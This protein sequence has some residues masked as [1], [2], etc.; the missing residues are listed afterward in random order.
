MIRRARFLAMSA[1]LLAAA[2]PA[3]RQL[4]AT[5][6]AAH[7]EVLAQGSGPVIVI[8]P[9]LGRGATDYDQLAEL[10]AEKGFRVLRPQP[11]GIGGST[12]PMTSLTLHDYA[13]DVAAVID[14]DA[15]GPVVVVGHAFGNYVARMLATD[16]P[17]LVSKLVLAAASP[18]KLPP[19][20]EG[21]V[22]APDIRKAIDA[23]KDLA[24]PDA[25]RLKALRTAFFAPGNDPHVW[26]DGWHPDVAAAEGAAEQATNRDEW[27]AG[28]HAPILVLQAAND[29]VA[30]IGQSSVLKD[31]LGD[32]RVSVL[33]I[34]HAGHAL[35]P[36][37]PAAVAE[38]IADYTRLR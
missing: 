26:L 20:E 12:G 13:A 11:R 21:P 8:L 19:G 31:M 10:L 2:A 5:N 27:F 32:G 33:L 9:S 22:I 28:G 17:D 30:P 6:G 23:S 24:L 7:I 38:A 29:T 16:R 15:K 14:Q 35:V 18:G 4:T 37:Q 3:P 36:E 34:D 25:E 1:L